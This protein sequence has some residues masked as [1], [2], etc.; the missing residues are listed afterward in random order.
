MPRPPQPEAVRAHTLARLVANEGNVSRTSKETGITRSTIIRWRNDVLGGDGVTPA[1]IDAMSPA[2][3]VKER[4]PLTRLQ[5]LAAIEDIANTDT[6]EVMGWDE[7]GHVLIT[8]SE[9][10]TKA[11]ARI[12]AG[13]KLKRRRLITGDGEEGEWE[14]EELEFRFRDQLAALL[15][16]ARMPHI[17]LIPASGVKVEVNDNRQQAFLNVSTDRL[18]AVGEAILALDVG[19]EA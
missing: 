8:A 3:S 7:K 1:L 19:D 6:R 16:L 17:G 14:T 2:Q 18:E 4:A 12:V 15:A 5:V 9:D 13:V 11:Q 10:L